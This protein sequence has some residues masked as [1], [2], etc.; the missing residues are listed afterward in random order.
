MIDRVIETRYGKLL[1]DVRSD[2]SV[3]LRTKE[4]NVVSDIRLTYRGQRYY[5]SFCLERNGDTW[6]PVGDP[7]FIKIGAPVRRDEAPKTYAREMIQAAV[8]AM[9]GF[10]D[11]YPEEMVQSRLDDLKMQADSY[12]FRIKEID[13]E[14]EGLRSKRAE[15]EARL[16][17][18]N[19]LIDELGRSV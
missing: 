7:Y 14:I 16:M 2:G 12:E 19:N 18:V 5:A 13:S 4:I 15:A 8:D 1:F 17:V 6:K 3:S 10:A 11:A 9:R